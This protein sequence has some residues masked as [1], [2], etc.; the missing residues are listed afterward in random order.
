MEKQLHHHSWC[1][2]VVVHREGPGKPKAQGKNRA[3]N[4]GEIIFLITSHFLFL[5]HC[6]VKPWLRFLPSQRSL[7]R[8]NMNGPKPKKLRTSKSVSDL[9]LLVFVFCHS[10]HVITFYPLEHSMVNFIGCLH[11]F[12]TF[13]LARCSAL[14]LFLHQPCTSSGS[15][16]ILLKTKNFFPLVLN[17]I[18]LSISLQCWLY[19]LRNT[20]AGCTAILKQVDYVWRPYCLLA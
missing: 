15:L 7:K 1:I 2:V 3:T 17:G 10:I 11:R 16:A 5:R 13:I 14:L 4:D 20:T 6:R 9:I 12:F 18:A 19:G 8:S